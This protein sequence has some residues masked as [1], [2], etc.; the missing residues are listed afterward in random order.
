MRKYGSRFPAVVSITA[1]RDRDRK[2]IG[3]LLSSSDNFARRQDDAARN[4]I[5]EEKG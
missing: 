5:E 3:Y 2:F 1:L 4:G